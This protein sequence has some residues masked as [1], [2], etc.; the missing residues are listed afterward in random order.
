MYNETYINMFIFIIQFY[1]TLIII[2][3]GGINKRNEQLREKMY[4]LTYKH[5]EGKLACASAQSDQSLRCPHDESLYP[6]LSKMH[7]VKIVIRL[8]KCAC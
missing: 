6:W 7:P 2:N 4:L 3:S 1:N 8:R 5:N